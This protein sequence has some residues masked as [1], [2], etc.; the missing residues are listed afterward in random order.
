MSSRGELTL[1]A[2][3]VRYGSRAA[4][5]IPRLILPVATTTALLGPSGAGKSTLLRL[6]AGLQRPDAGE[7]TWRRQPPRPPTCALLF[8]RPILIRGSVLHNASLGLRLRGERHAAARALPLLERLG[9]AERARQSART[10]S[11]GEAQRVALA[12]T[13]LLEPEVLLLDEPTAN[14]D[15]ENVAL[16]EELVREVQ[17]ERGT[18]VVWVTHAPSQAHRVASEVVLLLRGE[19]AEQSAAERFFGREASPAARD[20]LSGQMVW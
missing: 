7:V 16:F 5:R 11:G 2:V 17:A 3:E 4:L 6:L 14:L 9:L 8:Q 1:T 10:L 15:P 12:R 19:V 18:T 13:L 20:F